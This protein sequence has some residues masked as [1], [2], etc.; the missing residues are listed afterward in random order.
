MKLLFAFALFATSIVF[1]QDAKVLAS[2]DEILSA[3]RVEISPVAYRGMPIVFNGE[4]APNKICS[5]L[6]YSHAESYEK[7]RF[8]SLR[9]YNFATVTKSGI[10]T[11]SGS[12][13]WSYYL[14]ALTCLK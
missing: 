12:P 14:T 9:D 3:K 10:E 4:E 11:D 13:A 6:G 2:M 8:S 5:F 1:A 7:A